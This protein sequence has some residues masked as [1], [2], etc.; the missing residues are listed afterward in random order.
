M[1]SKLASNQKE[2]SIL[3]L[4]SINDRDLKRFAKRQFSRL[5]RK[6]MEISIINF[7]L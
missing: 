3:K 1:N 2:R 4:G 5:G 7:H 6:K